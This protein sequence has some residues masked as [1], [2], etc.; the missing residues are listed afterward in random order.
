MTTHDSVQVYTVTNPLEAEMVCNMLHAEGIAAISGGDNQAGYAGV[1][2]IPIMVRAEDAD[3]A[4]RI[5]ER[6]DQHGHNKPHPPESKR[7]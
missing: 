4:R 2:E 3:R 7:E 1:I 5:L 6:H